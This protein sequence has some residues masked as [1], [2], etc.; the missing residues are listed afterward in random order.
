MNRKGSNSSGDRMLRWRMAMDHEWTLNVDGSC[1]SA[2]NSGLRGVLRNN[3]S[4][5][6]GGFTGRLDCLVSFGVMQEMI[7]S[8]YVSP[9]PGVDVLIANDM[10]GVSSLRRVIVSD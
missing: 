5:W 2:Y 3:R 6:E 10:M 4:E 1:R 8:V 7:W 9:P